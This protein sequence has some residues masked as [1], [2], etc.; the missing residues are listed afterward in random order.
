M[1]VVTGATGKLGR[2]IVQAL[3]PQVDAA[4]IGVSVRDPDKADDL[5]RQGVRVRQGDFS[6]PASLGQAFE[7]ATQLLVVSSN[8]RA[9][10]GDP[11]AQHRNVIEAAKA[12]GVQRIVY[13]SHMA[14]SPSSAFPP[15]TDHAKTEAILAA[16]GIAWTSLRNGFYAS[17]VPFLIGK[18]VETGIIEA[19]EDGKSAWTTHADLGAAAAAILVQEGRFDGPTPPLTASATYDLADIAAMLS[20]ITGRSVTRRVVSDDEQTARLT[21][22]GAPPGMVSTTLGIYRAARAGEFA[23]IN[24]LLAELIGREPVALRDVLAQ[25]QE[26]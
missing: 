7:G 25:H 15:A 24:S 5:R 22:M 1:I 23:A 12:A 19:P 4:H 2:N 3:L 20:K 6:N 26:G 8:A 13:T 9:L 10:G 11:I 18:A 16:S 14:A 21:K 17:T